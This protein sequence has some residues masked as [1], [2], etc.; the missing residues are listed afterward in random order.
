MKKITML[1]LALALAFACV[2][3][4]KEK[5]TDKKSEGVLTHEQYLAA[6]VGD[7]I[8]I[9]AYVQA[10][11][12]LVKDKNGNYVV[13]VYAQDKDGAYFMYQMSCKEADYDKLKI[14]TKIK[15]KGKRAEYKGEIE[16]MD[17]TFEIMNGEYVAPVTD[18]TALLDKDELI[19]HQN[20]LV[21]FN[22]MT[23]APITYKDENEQ[24]VEVAFI[25]NHNGSGEEGDDLYFNVSYGDKVY[26]F[27]DRK[28]VV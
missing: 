22:G 8:T 2:G 10:K 24:D 14:G 16:L 21:A 5:D 13:S 27:T 15:V 11:Q 6:K 26:T 9:E 12:E 28:S 7:E 23:V 25:Y 3:C 17:A 4:G 19:N 1:I 20:K 18:V